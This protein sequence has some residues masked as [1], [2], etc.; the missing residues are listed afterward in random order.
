MAYAIVTL[1]L[2]FINTNYEQISLNSQK[3]MTQ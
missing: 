3:I 2:M 1:I